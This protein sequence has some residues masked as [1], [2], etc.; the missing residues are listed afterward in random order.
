MP[1]SKFWICYLFWM[2][3][4][5]VWAQTTQDPIR[6]V[7]EKYTETDEQSADYQDLYDLLSS[8]LQQP[9]NVNDPDDI[10]WSQSMLLTPI[11]LQALR[12]HISQFGPIIELYELQVI[13]ELEA[14]QI[15]DILPFISIRAAMFTPLKWAQLHKSKQQIIWQTAREFPKEKGFLLAEGDSGGFLGNG[16]KQVLRYRFDFNS[17]ITASLSAEKDAGERNLF[18]SGFDFYSAN[19]T[20]KGKGILKQLNIGDHQAAFGQ[21]LTFGSGL[22]FGK[23]AATL[24]ARRSFHGVRAYRGVNESLF[25]RG[26]ATEWGIRRWSF[27]VTL[28]HR[29]EDGRIESNAI[30]SDSEESV[31]SSLNG[32]GLHRTVRELSAKKEIPFSICA[33]NVRYKLKRGSI[34][35]TW[36]LMN[37]GVTISPDDKIYNRFYEHGRH[38]GRQGLHYELSRG[39]GLFYGESAIDLNGN[40]AHVHGMLVGLGKNLDVLSFIRKYDIGYNSLFT[41]GIGENSDTRNETGWY[42]GLN[43]RLDARWLISGYYDIFRFPWARFQVTSPGSGDEYLAE[44]Q[45]KPNKKT[46]FYARIRHQSKESNISE[47]SNTQQIQIEKIRYLR[48]HLD[49]ALGPELSAKTRVEMSKFQNINSKYYGSVIFQDIQLKRKNWSLS[50]RMAVFHIEDFDARIYAFEQDVPFSFSVFSMSKSGYRSY[51]MLQSNLTRHFE[52]WLRA[53]YTMYPQEKNLGSGLDMT[54]GNRNLGISLLLSYKW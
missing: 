7:L 33:G 23:S 15:L 8:A 54:E 27:F 31:I 50:A 30:D 14:R 34:G 4:L 52:G 41:N 26:L 51:L 16:Y 21:M 11:Q 39:P 42:T 19:L 47:E 13:P 9:L 35:Y 28:S 18:N 29:K 46:L 43:L 17:Q 5:W 10:R 24:N 22:A 6:V 36:A 37:S 49:Y 2:S 53:E 20:Y 38:F 44:L 45:Y 40:W 12:N 1:R 3:P 48:L 25:L 32:N